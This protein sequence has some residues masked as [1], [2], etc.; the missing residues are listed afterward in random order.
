MGH[1]SVDR[2]IKISKNV[3]LH[4]K[5]SPIHPRE[6]SLCPL[7]D[8]KARR[9]T[10]KPVTQVSSSPLAEVSMDISGPYIPS[11]E[12]ERSAL[13]IV[14]THTSNSDII[15]LNRKDQLSDAFKL[16]VA[17]AQNLFSAG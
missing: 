11:F 15:F 6:P 10:P 2:Y 17:Y 7:P 4:D 1:P 9:N 14:D 8:R 5:I 13:Q 3:P 12:E 16:Y